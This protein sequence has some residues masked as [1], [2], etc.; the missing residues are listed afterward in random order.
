MVF[1]CSSGWVV[2]I[3]EWKSPELPG[4]RVG[5]QL[6]LPRACSHRYVLFGL[7]V[8]HLLCVP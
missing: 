1:R 8:E 2:R 5:P 4:G 3:L 7:L 6:Y